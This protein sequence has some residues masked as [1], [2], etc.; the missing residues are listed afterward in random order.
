RPMATRVDG[1]AYVRGPS[2]EPLVTW[3]PVPGR[4]CLARYDDLAAFRK[5]A[6]VEAHGVALV[7]WHGSVFRSVDLRHFQLARQFEGLQ[8]AAVP[9]EARKVLGWSGDASPGAWPA[10]LQP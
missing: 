9:E 10:A 7:P 3:S 8:P 1:N 2:A 4:D 5:G 6:G